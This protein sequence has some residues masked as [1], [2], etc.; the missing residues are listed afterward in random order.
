[1]AI[2][3]RN[4][5]GPA[6]VTRNERG[7]KV[8][9]E[10]TPGAKLMAAPYLDKLALTDKTASVLEKQQEDGRPNPSGASRR[11]GTLPPP[12]ATIAA[13]I[14]GKADMRPARGRGS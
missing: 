9:P 12:S 6:I 14:R 10:Q 13:A 4:A 11:T 5:K 1:V 8:Q 2:V 3:T 7:A